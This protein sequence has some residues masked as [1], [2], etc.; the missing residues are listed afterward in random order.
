MAS[1]ILRSVQFI[2]QQTISIVHFLVH[3]NVLGMLS[4]SIL[5]MEVFLGCCPGG[6]TACVAEYR[7]NRLASM[8]MLI[9]CCHIQLCDCYVNLS[10]DH[11]I[12]HAHLTIIKISIQVSIMGIPVC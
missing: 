12:S 4:L 7:V 10:V 8:T 1:V 3:D 6:L 9:L 11:W 5:N 2:M